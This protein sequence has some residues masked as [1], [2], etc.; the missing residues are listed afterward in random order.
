MEMA[1]TAHGSF[2]LVPVHQIPL[3]ASLVSVAA[4][5]AR[6]QLKNKKKE[7]KKKEKILSQ[8]PALCVPLEYSLS[9][10]TIES[11]NFV[12]SGGQIKEVK[13]KR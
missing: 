12:S 10:W 2:C 11:M 9:S 8:L 13:N 1:V 7:K 6:Q 4:R 3:P 5:A